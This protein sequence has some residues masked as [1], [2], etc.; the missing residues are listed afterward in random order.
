MAKVHGGSPSIR[1]AAR[2]RRDPA[3]V[4]GQEQEGW[5]PQPAIEPSPS[6]LG[7]ALIRVLEVATFYTMFNLEP[8]GHAT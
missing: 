5:S 7:M 4:A 2:P 3:A 6:M 8:V 1:P